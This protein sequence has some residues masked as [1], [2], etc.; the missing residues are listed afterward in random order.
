MLLRG[1]ARNGAADHVESQV[2]QRFEADANFTHVELVAQPAEARVSILLY[3]AMDFSTDRDGGGD[4]T[5]ESLSRI[6]SPSA[7]AAALV[8][9]PLFA[10]RKSGAR[11]YGLA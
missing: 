7:A 10:E 6:A 8:L 9:R 1:H 3:D 11:I 2:L 4:Q 5:R